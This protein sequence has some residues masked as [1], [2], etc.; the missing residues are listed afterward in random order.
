MGKAHLCGLGCVETLKQD[1][2]TLTELKC[3]LGGVLGVAVA[4]ELTMQN[5]ETCK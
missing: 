3:F 5:L 1:H 2:S 4:A